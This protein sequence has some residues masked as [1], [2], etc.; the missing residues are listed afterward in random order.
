MCVS[1]A[2][3]QYKPFSSCEHFPFL[4]EASQDL[5]QTCHLVPGDAWFRFQPFQPEEHARALDSSHFRTKSHIMTCWNSVCLYT[6]RNCVSVFVCTCIRK[7]LQDKLTLD[8]VVTLDYC[9][10]LRHCLCSR[11][12]LSLQGIKVS[13]KLLVECFS[14]VNGFLCTYRHRESPKPRARERDS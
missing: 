9:L 13:A 1:W 6:A 8:L 3:S 10:F 4:L 2:R 14:L 7:Y 5:S 11:C 12:V